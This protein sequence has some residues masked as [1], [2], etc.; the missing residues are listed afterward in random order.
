VLLEDLA[1][2]EDR[3]DDRAGDVLADGEA[4]ENR[5]RDE[6]IHVVLSSPRIRRPSM[7]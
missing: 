7:T 4:R 1:N 6:L 2:D 3:R 5:Q